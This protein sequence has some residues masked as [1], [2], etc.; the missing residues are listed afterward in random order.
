MARS[1]KFSILRIT[2]D[3]RRGETVN[4][5]LIVFKN[6]GCDVRI[7]SNLS[8]LQ[9]LDG[10][11]DVA[12]VFDLESR[13]P[14]FLVG[15]ESTDEKIGILEEIG[16][17]K[18]G[19]VGEFHAHNADA[20]EK[21]L[22]ELMIE[23]VKPR[24]RILQHVRESRITVDLSK[25]LRS[26]GLLGEKLQDIEK[27]LVVQRFP[28]SHQLDL[29]ADFALKNGVMSLVKTIDFRAKNAPSAEKFR[30][31]CAVSFSFV[32]AREE[33][34]NSRRFVLYAAEKETLNSVERHLNVLADDAD[35]VLNYESASDRRFLL[36]SLEEAATGQMS[37]N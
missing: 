4:V 12:D 33:F 3:F 21:M 8:K 14:K 27:H 15:I 37:I 2:P 17:L 1:Y 24:R 10:T 16:I 18:K 36:N 20:Y 22:H 32:K 25:K 28:I 6:D 23:L 34:S 30:E 5:G 7:L 9:N 29:Y 19:D 31:A 35:H 11:V 13:I 26:R